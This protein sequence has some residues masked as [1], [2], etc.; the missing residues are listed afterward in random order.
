MPRYSRRSSP[1]RPGLFS[2][3]SL[4]PARRVR[5]D[6]PG[7]SILE[8]IS[9]LVAILNQ[10]AAI[11][12]LNP[13]YRRAITGS[14]ANLVGTSLLALVHPDDRATV[15]AQWAALTRT[16]QR[17]TFRQRAADGSWRWL[18]AQA[19]P[20]V[21]RGSAHVVLVARDVT[22]QREH[23]AIRLQL[24]AIVESSEDAIISKH[25]DGT[26]VSWN[27]SAE[28]IYGYRADEVIG[29]SIAL[30]V[31][32]DLPDELPRLLG[33]L[34]QG[35]RIERYETLRVRKDGTPIQVA[36]T[37]SPIKDA[38]GTIIGASTIARDITERVEAENEQR[39]LAA[40]VQQQ[41]ER[42]RTILTTVPGVVWEAWGQPD[43]ATQ[44]IDFVSD[45]V[46][47]MLG[48]SVQEWLE[49][50]NFWLSIVHP[51]D[52][53]YAVQRANEVFSATDASGSEFR[54]ITRDGRTI[55]VEVRSAPI[56]D[57]AGKPVGMRGV[58]MD[59]TGR[60]RA[61]ERERLLVE[62]S[63]VLAR[64]LDYETTLQSIASLVASTL[65]DWCIVD[66]LEEDG[67]PQ[68]LVVAH[69]DPAKV[70]MAQDLW[71]YRPRACAAR[72]V[73][74]SGQPMLL[75]EISDETLAAEACDDD[76]L[77]LLGSLGPSSAMC[78]PLIARDRILGT[79]TF[80]IDTPGRHYT[81]E[82]LIL[83]ED[84]ASRAALAVDNARLY[85]E[86]QAALRTRDD[87]LSIAAHELKT[88]LTSLL[89]F[90]QM[91]LRRATQ[92]PPYT[93]SRRDHQGLE[94]VAAQTRRLHDLIEDLLNIGR[95][96]AGRLSVHRQVMD[97]VGFV[98][99]IVADLE[100][101]LER[102]ALTLSC[103]DRALLIDGDPQ[104]LEEVL[105]NLLQNAL[106]YSPCGGCIHV[107]VLE[108]AGQVSIAVSDQGIG[109]PT[110]AQP[111]LFQPFYR[112]PT[113]AA[114]NISG[115]GIGLYVVKEIATLHGGSVD[116]QSAEGQ[117]STF[118]VR[119]PLHQHADDT[120][121]PD[122]ARARSS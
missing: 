96:R 105:Q 55:W 91:L 117:G 80:I 29:R 44:Q 75:T 81:P 67:V 58:M 12:D 14:S 30:L 53:A 42:F 111:R 104:R 88:P 56:Y 109:I 112:A 34:R 41:H 13:A 94:I 3:G 45:Y 101:M 26:I 107:E 63:S 27:A 28:R 37:I 24:A 115:T 52:R 10:H 4:P 59:I 1:P 68:S 8:Q 79:L 51:D 40:L 116:V 114:A 48:Y 62:A 36:L 69:R 72:S 47:T 70:A 6:A 22:A 121:M 100:P 118:T 95:L 87:F 76:H 5:P 23:E 77:R 38:T 78:V 113:S 66:V 122:K 57:A 99:R 46:E 25:L 93:L 106:K 86:A 65:A 35:E 119:L 50:P 64:S 31:P 16:A 15:Q 21:W 2:I 32:P 11:V 49:T 43:A 89:G 39:R 19:D 7:L 71:P 9:D 108:Q 74:R 98:R 82:D 18:E 83:A 85:R 102:H 61:E 103:P 110:A 54:W 120:A 84:L 97:I 73:L 90:T 60:R 20:V 33:R 92:E 17:L